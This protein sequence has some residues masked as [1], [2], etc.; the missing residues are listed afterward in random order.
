MLIYFLN[1]LI[2]MKDFVL[3]GIV[4]EPIELFFF[5][6]SFL[7]YKIHFPNIDR[8]IIKFPSSIIKHF[9]VSHWPTL[10]LLVA[11]FGQNLML[12]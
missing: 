4:Q 8:K 6:S 9:A 7:S 1:F 3:F 10:D 12:I 5:K 11:T 2:K